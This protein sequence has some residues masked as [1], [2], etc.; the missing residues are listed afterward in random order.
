MQNLVVLRHTGWTYAGG[1]VR[2][3]CGRWCRLWLQNKCRVNV[4]A[5]YW[6]QEKLKIW[7][8]GGK[9]WHHRILKL[10]YGFLWRP[11]YCIILYTSE[12]QTL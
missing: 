6:H 1:R 9:N 11:E 5:S 8:S 10:V 3:I 7:E 4:A 2:T 12:T